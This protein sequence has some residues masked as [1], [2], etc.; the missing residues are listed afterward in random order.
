MTRLKSG[1]TDF[2]SETCIPHYVRMNSY[3]MGK[4][5]GKNQNKGKKGYHSLKAYFDLD[6]NME[7][8]LQEFFEVAH[9]S[10]PLPSPLQRS[11]KRKKS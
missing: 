8:L 2:H 3:F 7:I 1:I 10:P 6:I 4:R 11:Y 9:P 5:R